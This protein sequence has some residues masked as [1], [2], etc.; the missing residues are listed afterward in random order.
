[1]A[2]RDWQMVID[3]E[4]TDSSS[5]ETL[6]VLDPATGEVYARAPDGTEADV[7]SAIEAAREAFGEWRRVKPETRGEFLFELADALK[8]HHEELVE[9]ETHENGKP[10]FQSENDVTN[11]ERITR[12][13][14]G[15][16]DKLR[17]ESV[18]DTAE[19][20]LKTVF[21]PYGVVGIVIPWNWPPIHTAEFATVAIATGNTVVLKPAPETPLSSL[22]IAELAADVLPAGVL[23]VVSGGTGPGVALTSHADV[24]KLAFTGNDRTGE[25]ILEAAASHITPSMMELGGKNPAIVFPDADMEKAVSGLVYNTFYNSGQA[26]TNPERLLVHEAIYEE[27]LERFTDRVEDIVVG[28]GME[29]RT[30]VGPLVSE[31]QQRT[32]LDAIERA[33][34]E[35]AEIIAQAETPDDREPEGGF[36]QAQT[37]AEDLSGGFYVPPTVFGDVEPGMDLVRE[38]VFGPVVAPLSFADEAEALEMANDTDYGLAA[39]VWTGD[40]SRAHRVTNE[41]E[42]G[43][44]TVNHPTRSRQGMPFGGYKRSGIG[45]KKGFTETMREYVQIKS[46]QMD[47]TDETFSFSY[48]NR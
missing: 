5:G 14:G 26:C 11:A 44:L 46:I 43:I 22:R 23:N 10:L 17:G 2:E 48:G 40:V 33:R 38:E 16:A 21:E 27:F 28:N 18:L 13:Y 12:F 25:K 24:D 42:A 36:A 35:G 45:R 29:E 20:V 30:E 41:L 3:G 15:A 37:P 47:L 19:E 39:S 6:D 7:E 32:V 9:L 4:S 31:S 34:E 1:M 8:K